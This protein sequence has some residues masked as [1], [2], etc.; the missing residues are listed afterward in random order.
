M[1]RYALLIPI[2]LLLLIFNVRLY[3][4][5]TDPSGLPRDAFAQ[6]AAM[7]NAVDGGAASEMQALFPEGYFFTALLY[8]DSWL[9]V[10]AH[11]PADDPRYADGLA[12]ASQA[13]GMLDDPAAY[14]PFPQH[15]DP[16]YGIFYVGW[17]AWLRGHRLSLM[18][19]DQWEADQVDQLRAECDQIAGAL[20]RSESPYLQSYAG[21]AW[22]V[23]TVVAVAALSL[24]DDLAITDHH[25]VITAWKE[26]VRSDAAAY[27]GLIPHRTEPYIEPPRATSQSLITRFLAEIDP[28]WAYTSYRNLR[29]A[30]MVVPL[31]VREYPRGAS[32]RGDVDSGPLVF[33][34]S[35]SSTVVSI[36]AA[37][38]NG[39]SAMAQSLMNGAE[40][41]GMGIRV[42][43]EKRYGFG[44]L[45]IGDLFLLWAKTSHNVVYGQP[46]VN[47]PPLPY[48]RWSYHVASLLLILLLTLWRRRE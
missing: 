3:L 11:L 39:D 8:G 6:L 16:E 18:D 21:Q 23:D 27:D 12:E 10:I 24:C 13:L 33:G 46:E 19:A 47:Y 37:R 41:I 35:A 38:V 20:Q 30:Y 42:R 22:P 36:G 4:P 9:N 25:A 32:G 28:E 44:L 43:G 15:L 29:T 26:A 34:I 17:K 48:W 45:P 7:E 14:A 31:G 2:T 40:V 5:L 1:L